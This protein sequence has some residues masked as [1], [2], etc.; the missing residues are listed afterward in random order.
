[1][2]R[3]VSIPGSEVPYL[4][5]HAIEQE[6]TVLLAEYSERFKPVV[7]PPVPVDEIIELHLEL[8]FELKDLQEL[9]RYGDVHGAT[10]ISEGRI[11]VDQSLDPHENPRKLGR[12]R[13][14]AGHETGH[15]RLHRKHYLKDTAQLKLFDE[16]AEKP[17]Y[18]CRSSARKQ[19]VEWQADYFSAC[20]LM[21]REMVV[22]AWEKRR[23]S[24]KSMALD[25]LRK[26]ETEIV[27]SEVLRR[28]SL[29]MDRE[30]IDNTLLERYG[31][32]LAEQFQ[33][34]PEA[35]RI[36]LEE[37]RLH[38]EEGSN[39][40]LMVGTAFFLLAVFPV[41]GT[42]TLPS[43]RRMVNAVRSEEATETSRQ[44]SAPPTVRGAKRT[45]DCGTAL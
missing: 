40:V 14:T 3:R 38:A 22:K 23:G 21:P 45:V 35:M 20:L 17:A 5:K 29:G 12:F 43:S 34:S 16:T 41:Y 30:T 18:I 11:A 26:H 2:P 31:R 25:D 28:G 44:R 13:F 27:S 1:M 33:V 39:A 7:E 32:P 15:W 37:L 42:W 24:L 10:W 4:S 6:A 36:R 8:T 9:F 19:R